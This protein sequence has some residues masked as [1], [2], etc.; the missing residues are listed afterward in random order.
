MTDGK[1]MESGFIDGKYIVID[2][3]QLTPKLGNSTFYNIF[4]RPFEYPD[5]KEATTPKILTFLLWRPDD[6]A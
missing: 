3:Y 5:M 4:Y 6:E 2:F 1:S